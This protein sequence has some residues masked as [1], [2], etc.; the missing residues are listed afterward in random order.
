MSLSNADLLLKPEPLSTLWT[1]RYL[2]S[3]YPWECL[4][5]SCL[6]VPGNPG[7]SL[8][9]PGNPCGF[10]SSLLPHET[11][12]PGLGLGVLICSVTKD[13]Q[14]PQVMWPRKGS[15]CHCPGRCHPRERKLSVLCRTVQERKYRPLLRIQCQ[16]QPSQ[17]VASR[18]FQVSS[19]NSTPARV[20]C[21]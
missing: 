21:Q 11:S 3:S 15:V 6:H 5:Q 2:C 18:S 20:H 17:Q 13:F 9:V 10:L 8:L 16:C 19:Q 1:T 12:C 14:A 7:F 4:S